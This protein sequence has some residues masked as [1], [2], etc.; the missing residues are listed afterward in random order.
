MDETTHVI[1][2]RIPIYDSLLCLSYSAVLAKLEE[3]FPS[4]QVEEEWTEVAEYKRLE[5]FVRSENLDS[6]RGEMMLRQLRSKQ[7]SH[8]PS[9]RLS[10]SAFD[11]DPKIEVSHFRWGITFRRTAPFSD[12]DADSIATFLTSIGIGT[13]ESYTNE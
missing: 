4:I 13:V 3:S 5:E 6:D 2:L 9:F 11:G 1:S 8:G 10:M 7:I 12:T